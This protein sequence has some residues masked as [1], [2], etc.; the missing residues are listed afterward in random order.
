MSAFR[1]SLIALLGVVTF[2]VP[3]GVSYAVWRA[4]A[5]ATVTVRIS[6]PSTSGPSAP[7][8][9]GCSK[10]TEPKNNGDVVISW[11]GSAPKYRLDGSWT[12]GSFTVL[13]L[14]DRSRRLSSPPDSTTNNKAVTLRVVAVDAQGRETTSVESIALEWN[15]G[16]GWKCPS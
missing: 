3:A 9:L 2:S 14:T 7:T 11:S 4:Q 16:Q 1:K 15:N 13:D 6:A 8:A 5:S 12:G 10:P